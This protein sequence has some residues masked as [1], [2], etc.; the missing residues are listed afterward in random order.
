MSFRSINS[1]LVFQFYDK[2]I[3]APLISLILSPGLFP[4]HL[5]SSVISA[6]IS[7]K[8]HFLKFIFIAYTVTNPRST[9]KRVLLYKL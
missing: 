5:S 3:K 1:G 6:N 2:E 9:L 4:L 8:I 7:Q